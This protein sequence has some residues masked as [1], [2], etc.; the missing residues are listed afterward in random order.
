MCTLTTFDLLTVLDHLLMQN[1]LV[2]SFMAWWVLSLIVLSWI[3]S[4][5]LSLYEHLI[6][7]ENILLN[8]LMRVIILGWSL[9]IGSYLFYKFLFCLNFKV[10]SLFFRWASSMYCLKRVMKL[11]FYALL[12]LIK[13]LLRWIDLVYV[14][15]SYHWLSTLLL[16]P[17]FSTSTSTL[18]LSL[19]LF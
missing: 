15:L 1:H 7:C 17:S 14:W 4:L 8:W 16:F 5:I 2:L 13:S 19:L 12:F 10:L 3:W 18:I 11:F 9:N 6:Y